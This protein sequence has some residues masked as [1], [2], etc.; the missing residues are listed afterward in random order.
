[1]KEN[2]SRRIIKVAQEVKSNVDNGEKIWEIKRKVQRKIQTAHTIKD[3]KN[4]N[5]IECSSQI[6]EEY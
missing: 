5:K 1:M 3:E 6:L 2:I 4:P